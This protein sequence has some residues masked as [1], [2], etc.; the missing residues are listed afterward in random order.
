VSVGDDQ[1][2]RRIGSE[3][4][5][6]EGEQQYEWDTARQIHQ[7]SLAI[8]SQLLRLPRRM[9]NNLPRIIFSR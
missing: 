5:R 6:A 2:E 8:I 1:V 9:Q 7:S 4:K 3:G